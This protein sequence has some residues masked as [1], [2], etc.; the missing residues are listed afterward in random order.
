MKLSKFVC[1][2]A[3]ILAPFSLQAQSSDSPPSIGIGVV[4]GGTIPMGTYGDV[5]STGF[6]F[7]GFLDFGRRFGPAG[8]RADVLYHGFGDRDILTGDPSSA[9]V[10]FSNK[11]S[12][13]SGT[14]NLVF[15]VPVE[16]SAIRPYVIGGAGGYYVKN[17]PKCLGVTC[18]TLLN[19]SDESTTKLGVNGGGGVEFGLG[20]ANFFVEARYH[21]IFSGTPDVTCIG[22]EG[23][24]RA[25]AKLLPV[26]VGLTLRF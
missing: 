8:L 1:G 5:A 10:T 16:A 12:M 19:V 6:H 24:N 13:I 15:G 9:Q 7:G 23:C 21:H 26:S 18:G 17:S 14:L 4:G 20:G 3:V 2:M 25:A 22:E 11:Y